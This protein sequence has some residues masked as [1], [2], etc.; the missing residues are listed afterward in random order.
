MAGVRLHHPEL[1]NCTYTVTN[2]AVPLK[3]P[4]FCWACSG[5]T[6]G[7]SPRTVVHTFKT[8][9]LDIDAV[10]DVV[11]AEGVFEMMQRTG[12]LKNLAAMKGIAKPD[13]TII[14]VGAANA[15]LT[16]SAEHGAL[17]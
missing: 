8:I 10:G 16:V 9:H 7:A 4:M 6:E 13:K 1:R 12:L 17:V 2:Y 3:A 15:P 5:G 14:E 11:V